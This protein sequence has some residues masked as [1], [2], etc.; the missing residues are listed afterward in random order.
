MAYAV[1]AHGFDQLGLLRRGG[2]DDT[3]VGVGQDMR[4][5]RGRVGLVDGHGDGAAGQCGHVDERPLIGGGGQDRQVVADLEPD[6]D[7]AARK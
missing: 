4:D 2:Y 6:A 3:H 7:E 5:L 1:G